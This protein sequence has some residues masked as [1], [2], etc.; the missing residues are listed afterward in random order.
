MNKTAEVILWLEKM[1]YDK[2][3]PF[4]MTIENLAHTL[5]AYS[6]Q[7]PADSKTERKAIQLVVKYKEQL[8]ERDEELWQTKN[9]VSDLQ[10]IERGLVK[11]LADKDKQIAHL[12]KINKVAD[13]SS[14]SPLVSKAQ[15]NGKE[16]PSSVIDKMEKAF[17]DN[18]IFA[19][20]NDEFP[21]KHIFQWLRDNF[22][23]QA[24]MYSEE[25]MRKALH[26]GMNEIIRNRFRDDG[27]SDTELLEP[28]FQ[29]LPAKTEREGEKCYF[30]E[31]KNPFLKVK[32]SFCPVAITQ[33]STTPVV[34]NPKIEKQSIIAA[35]LI[36]SFL[37][38]SSTLSPYF[39]FSILIARIMYLPSQYE[40]YY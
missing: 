36:A 34:D 19:D 28:L 13:A 11:K 8:T 29:S 26:I 39:C 31:N 12:K 35:S 17:K 40:G 2:S 4:S 38:S 23:A 1:G 16:L 10:Q 9:V 33:K 15:A 6:A 30:I 21:P 27:K 18:H 5:E 25:D 37:I 20:E 24:N 7:Q 32:S 22:K 3:I 14:F